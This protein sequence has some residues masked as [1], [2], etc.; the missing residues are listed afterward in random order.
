[1]PSTAW[2]TVYNSTREPENVYR[3]PPG[4]L[5]LGAVPTQRGGVAQGFVVTVQD[6]E[7]KTEDK[8]T[9]GRERRPPVFD[10][11]APLVVLHRLPATAV[12]LSASLLLLP[13]FHR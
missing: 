1:M 6:H 8:A 5:V 13:D 10:I 2:T 4:G 11:R 7:G 9:G 3:T 12:C